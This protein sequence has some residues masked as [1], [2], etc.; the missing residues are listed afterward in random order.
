[1][2]KREA[3]LYTSQLFAYF[4]FSG[5]SFLRR[6]G[7]VLKLLTAIKSKGK[8]IKFNNSLSLLKWVVCRLIV[9]VTPTLAC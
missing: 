6:G 8:Q 9:W 3:M 2:I 7:K 4:L 1:M 5:Q